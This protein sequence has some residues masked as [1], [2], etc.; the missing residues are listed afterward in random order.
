MKNNLMRTLLRRLPALALLC[1]VAFAAPAFAADFCFGAAGMQCGGFRNGELV[2]IAFCLPIAEPDRANCLVSGGSMTHDP[3][4]ADNPNG[5][6]CGGN[7]SSGACQGAWDRA[8]NRAVWGYQWKRRVNTA[9]SNTT[10][11]VVQPDY[12]ARDGA[13]IHRNDVGYCCSNRS[14]RA[15]WWDRIG[16]PNLYRCD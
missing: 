10:G 16:R 14:H 2:G 6:Q 15:S 8:V 12:C 11:D 7:N 5:V 13:P 9:K 1:G 4:C 3:C